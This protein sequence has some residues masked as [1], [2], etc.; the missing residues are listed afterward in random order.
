MNGNLTK[1]AALLAFIIGAMAI[2]SGGQVVLGKIQDYYV[3]GWLPIYNFIVGLLSAFFIAII[4]WRGSKIALLATIATFA[5][6][7]MVML[8]LQTSYQDVVASESIKAMTIR[9]AVWLIILALMIIQARKDKR[10]PNYG[11]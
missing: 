11:F 10:I 1:I 9:I 3:I 5:S 8:V 6:H 2:F 4:I 7:A